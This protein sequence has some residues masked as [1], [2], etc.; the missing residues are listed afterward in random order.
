MKT[1]CYFKFLKYCEEHG[2]VVTRNKYSVKSVN[3]CLKEDTDKF[4]SFAINKPPFTPHDLQ[5]FLMAFNKYKILD[6][7]SL[8]NECEEKVTSICPITEYE[9]KFEYISITGY[10]SSFDSIK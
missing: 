8:L 10:H 3:I 4:V 5:Y 7:G 2:C 1:L 9:E 6:Y